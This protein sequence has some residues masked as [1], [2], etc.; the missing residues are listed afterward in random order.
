MVVYMK[1][2]LEANINNEYICLKNNATELYFISERTDPL[3]VGKS[4]NIRAILKY[5]GKIPV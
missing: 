2:C 1:I 4:E 3:A 5:I